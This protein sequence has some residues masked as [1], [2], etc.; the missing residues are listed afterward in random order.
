MLGFRC[1]INGLHTDNHGRNLVG[2]TGDV[3]PPLFQ[4]G[5]IRGH[6]P[7]LFSLKV[8]NLERFQKIKVMFV[9]FSLK[10]FAC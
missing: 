8:L 5:D 2:D 4:T 3:P 10:S 9:T 7:P 6:V 1:S